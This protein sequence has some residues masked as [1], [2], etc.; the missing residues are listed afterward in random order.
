MTGDQPKAGPTISLNLPLE[1]LTW[2]SL[3]WFVDQARAAN[4]DP[5]EEILTE[6]HDDQMAP[7][8]FTLILPASSLPEV[9]GTA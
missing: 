7:V 2:R 1:D 3:F 6:W 4:V 5:D 8:G 9:S